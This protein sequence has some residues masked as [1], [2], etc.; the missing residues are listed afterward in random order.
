M[1]GLLQEQM[2][3]DLK[4]L[5]WECQDKTFFTGSQVLGV[6]ERVEARNG[7]ARNCS[8]PRHRMEHAQHLSTSGTACGPL[9]D[10]PSKHQSYIWIL[11]AS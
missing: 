3:L 8:R 6:F 9:R 4:S 7:G 10:C 11:E 2:A 5:G 1:S